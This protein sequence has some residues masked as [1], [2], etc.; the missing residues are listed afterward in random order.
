MTNILVMLVV[1]LVRV[2]DFTEDGGKE[3][4]RRALGMLRELDAGNRL[5]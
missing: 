2:A 5:W 4:L 3:L 1:P